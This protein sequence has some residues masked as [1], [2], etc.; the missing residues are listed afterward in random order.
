[1]QF[2]VRPSSLVLIVLG[3]TMLALGIW[4]EDRAAVAAPLVIIGALVVVAGVVVETWA[5]LE[6][7]SLS[8][9]GIVLKRRAPTAEQLTEAGLPPAVAEEIKA[10]IDSLLE[11]L[12][13][14]ID[15]RVDKKLKDRRNYEAALRRITEDYFPP[16]G[17]A[18]VPGQGAGKAPYSGGAAVPGYDAPVPQAKPPPE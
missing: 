10:W 7:M 14:I 15:T 18:A 3:L 13:R 9:A 11:V 6:E 1:M 2:P 8:Q 5:D 17:G 16:T 12:P 4:V